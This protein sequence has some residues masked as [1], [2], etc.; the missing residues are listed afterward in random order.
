MSPFN[1]IFDF[2]RGIKD[3]LIDL[4]RR[5]EIVDE[6]CAVIMERKLR[7]PD[8]KNPKDHYEPFPLARATCHSECFLPPK[9]FIKYFY[10]PFKKYYMQFVERGGR[11]YMRGEGSFACNIDVMQDLPAGTMSIMLDQDD[12]FDT[13][14][15]Y[16]KDKMPIGAGI[17][18]VLLKH[19][20]VEECKDYVKKCFDT[21]APGGGFFFAQ[22]EGMISAN[23]AK[24]ENLEAVFNLAN[25][26]SYKK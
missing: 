13:Y 8:F 20:T 9:Q 24:R 4:R 15:K 17:T 2:Y 22:N 16:M 5:P 14:E 23:D 21:F 11:Y 12:P 1:S 7:A 25:E 18:A 6:A 19:G 3:S 26:L 10:E